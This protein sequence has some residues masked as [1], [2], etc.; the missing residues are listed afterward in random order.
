MNKA[1]CQV[2]NWTA[3]KAGH[4]VA[5]ILVPLLC[6]LWIW[7]TGLINE[8]TL[9]LSV[10]AISLTQMV[11]QSQKQETEFNE[12]QLAELIKAIPGA[13]NELA[14]IR[15]SLKEMEKLKNDQTD[16]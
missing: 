10:V 15:P 5:I 9:L 12:M 1:F 16:K 6:I 2:C 8:L 3:N 13:R 11:L 4:P 7:A 14:K